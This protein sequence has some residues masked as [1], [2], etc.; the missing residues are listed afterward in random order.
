VTSLLDALPA[1]AADCTC[2]VGAGGKKTTMYALADRIERAVVTA[3]VR[4]P[5]FADRMGTLA[6][7][8][9]PANAVT[10]ADPRDWPVGVV[11]GRDDDRDRYLGYDTA[12]VDALVDAVDVPVVVKADGARSRW[13]TAPND[14]EPQLPARADLVVPVASARVVGEPLDEERVHR[15]ELVGSVAGCEVGATLTAE[16]VATLLSSTDGG[17]KA[18]PDGATVRPLVN[19]V[20]GPAEER[21]ARA[22]AERVAALPRVDAVVLARMLDDDPIVDVVA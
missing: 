10:D 9:D 13:L 6:V 2:F 5:P 18:V 3:T 7:G 19:M 14:R 15:P 11:A 8:D 21:A 20:D 12:T 1:D 16:H 22:V 17:L 4:I